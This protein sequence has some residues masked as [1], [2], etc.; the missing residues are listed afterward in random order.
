LAEIV[1]TGAAGAAVI[2]AVA[3]AADPTLAT[4][5]LARRMGVRA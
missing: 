5:N 3:A 1:A 4:R 2:S